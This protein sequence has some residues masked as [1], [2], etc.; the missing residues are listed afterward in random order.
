MSDLAQ[1]SLATLLGDF[2]ET[3]IPPYLAV[4]DPQASV[5]IA[6]LRFALKRSRGVQL[7]AARIL[8]IGG[9]PSPISFQST[10]ADAEI[11]KLLI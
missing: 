8:G 1:P 11:G 9:S 4:R 10:M 7:E 2:L 6:L 3:R 5:E